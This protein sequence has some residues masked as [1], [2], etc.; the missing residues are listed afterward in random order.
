MSESYGE[1]AGHWYL[2]YGADV[3]PAEPNV[4]YDPGDECG[5]CGATLM[6]EAWLVSYY[7]EDCGIACRA[8]VRLEATDYEAREERL[9]QILAKHATA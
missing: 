4:D 6:G 8:C 2:G 1:A 9:K 7:R 5:L 3:R